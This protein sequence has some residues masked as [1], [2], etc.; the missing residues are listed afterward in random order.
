MEGVRQWHHLLVVG[1]LVVERRYR[2]TVFILCPLYIVTETSA[3]SWYAP[4]LTS[5]FFFS[6]HTCIKK[7][8]GFVGAILP[9]RQDWRA[10]V[11]YC[12][13]D[14]FLGPIFS[15]F[16]RKFLD[17]SSQQYSE[18]ANTTEYLRVRLNEAVSLTQSKKWGGCCAVLW[19][20]Q[21]STIYSSF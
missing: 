5:V 4:R 1:F 21:S 11:G 2:T 18:G 17:P 14:K 19:L 20:S 10:H 9:N 13:S 3:V 12:R 6:V 8:A 16:W 15:I 7:G